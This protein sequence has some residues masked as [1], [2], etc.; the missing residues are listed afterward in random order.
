MD[1]S[2]NRPLR[3]LRSLTGK[4]IDQCLMT[5]TPRPTRLERSRLQLITEALA[6]VALIISAVTVFVMA[7]AIILQ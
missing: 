4:E 1:Q 6:S 5:M 7:M 2:T 3:D